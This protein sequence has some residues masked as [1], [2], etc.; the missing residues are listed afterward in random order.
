MTLLGW[1]IRPQFLK[2]SADTV[3]IEPNSRDR[4]E[5]TACPPCP[6]EQRRYLHVSVTSAK[7]VAQWGHV[8]VAADVDPAASVAIVMIVNEAEIVE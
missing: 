3:A 1:A 5:I 7:A 2:D 6:T 8:V 4:P